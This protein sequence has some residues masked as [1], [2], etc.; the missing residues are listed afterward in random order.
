[1][2]DCDHLFSNVEILG[3]LGVGGSESQVSANSN[4]IGALRM[5]SMTTNVFWYTG[6]CLIIPMIVTWE[7][8]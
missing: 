1:M 4:Q 3:L 8:L 2:N 5:S 6:A 7:W